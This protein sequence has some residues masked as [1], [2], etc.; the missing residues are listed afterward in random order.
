MVV[1]PA[2]G[3]ATIKPLCP[4]PIGEIRSIILEARLPS[5]NFNL[6]DGYAGT[7]SSNDGLKALFKGS[8][9]F[10]YNNLSKP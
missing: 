8:S 1:L 7:R 5:P 6:S 3:G 9:P 10:M 4:L 2:L